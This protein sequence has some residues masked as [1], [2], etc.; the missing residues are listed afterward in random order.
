MRSSRH[1][2]QQL[3]Y[4]RSL[5]EQSPMSP[6]VSDARAHSVPS[7]MDATYGSVHRHE[8]R[9]EVRGAPACPLSTLYAL[10]APCAERAASCH[11]AIGRWI[12]FV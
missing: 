12:I 4:A 1:G 9:M 6:L 3:S 11:V 10:H 7:P 2:S 5:V 8:P